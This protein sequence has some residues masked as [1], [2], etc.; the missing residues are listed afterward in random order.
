MKCPACG[1]KARNE[2]LYCPKCGQK[3]E[4]VPPVLLDDAANV[5]TWGDGPAH[6]RRR[7]CGL[8]LLVVLV[9]FLLMAGVLGLGVA[10]VYVGLNDRNKVERQA[11]AEHY[12]LGVA[13]LEQGELELAIAELEF[14]VRLNP[15]DQQAMAKLAEA[16]QRLA[17]RPSP[18]AVRVEAKD[19]FLNEL[20]AAYARQDW[21][22]V[23]EL[24]DQLAA[25][26]PT[27]QRDEINVMLSDA[28]YNS[29]LGLIEEN[30]LEE[31]VRLL[32]QSLNLQPNNAQAA[33][34]KQLATL[35]LGGM[36]YW[37]A[38]WSRVI[39]NLSAL[40]RLA[41]AYKDV[42]QRMQSAYVA[43]GD[44]L[45]G[46]QD[47]C[48]AEQQYAHA[49]EIAANVEVAAK[50]DASH[51]LCGTAPSTTPAPST[52]KG[53]SAPSGTFVGRVTELIDIDGNRILIR[54]RVL[55]KSA[56]GVSNVRVQIK[57]FTFSA[58]AVTDGSGQY[59]FDGLNTPVTYTLTLLDKPAIPFDA[60]TTWGKLTW[61]NF[62][63][64]K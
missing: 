54:G 51:K 26:D 14:V 10:G 13:H 49:L 61:V 4:Q 40:Y 39:E 52:P 17:A 41:P 47:W 20:R 45:D 62:E 22:K 8:S 46:Q 42:R 21:Q 19:V 23:V 57:A 11:A 18:T 25:L 30:R 3:L 59:S 34:A 43:Y 33:Q 38:D 63:E 2:D 36:N 50:R 44:Q 35:Y 15:Q 9:G 60:G 29:A 24:A 7:G 27:Y 53:P 1:H 32:D 48:A 5:D 16:R 58:V 64:A 31:A 28:F 56:Q 37:G 55:N 12:A 6:V